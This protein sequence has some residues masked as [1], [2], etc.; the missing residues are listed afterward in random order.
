ML[1]Q[2]SDD[3]NSI[4]THFLYLGKKKLKYARLGAARSILAVGT[5]IIS[6]FVWLYSGSMH[7]SNRLPALVCF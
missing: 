4:R 7:I 3:G 5:L 6:H 2:L 1:N